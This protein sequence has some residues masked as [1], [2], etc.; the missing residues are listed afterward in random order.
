MVLNKK[1]VLLIIEI[2]HVPSLTTLTFTG[3]EES[4]GFRSPLIFHAGRIRPSLHLVAAEHTEHHSWW[5]LVL[6]HLALQGSHPMSNLFFH[7]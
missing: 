4:R 5:V 7:Q 2:N 3:I 1:A 6:T